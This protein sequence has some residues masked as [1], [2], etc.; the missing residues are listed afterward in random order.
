MGRIESYFIR[1]YD[2]VSNEDRFK[3]Y[4]DLYEKIL[5]KD[6]EWH[7]F[8]E[9]EFDELRFHSKYKKGVEKFLDGNSMVKDHAEREFGWVDDQAIVEEYKEYF[10]AIFHHNT[11]LSLELY[12][13][14]NEVTISHLELI[15]DRTVYSFL[16][17]SAL[18]SNDNMLEV[19]VM[20]NY[21]IDRAFY[22]GMMYQSQKLKEDEDDK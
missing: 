2:D 9:G 22:M 14:R 8:T 4:V 17:M 21:L 1:F 7:Y 6:N 5:H 12:K 16:N 20:K 18:Y 11:L 19:K 3:L 15:M 10:I 13:K